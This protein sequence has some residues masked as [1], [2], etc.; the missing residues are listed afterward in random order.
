MSVA[1]FIGCGHLLRLSVAR[2][3]A[4]YTES[5]GAYGGDE[6]DF[7]LRA[8]D[9]GYEIIELAGVHVWHDKTPLARDL[10][11]QHRSGVC[12]DLTLVLRR[13]P[14]VLVVPTVVVKFAKHLLFSIKHGLFRAGLLGMRDFLS[15]APEIWRARLPVRAASLAQFYSLSRAPRK[16]AG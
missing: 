15:A 10:P 16:A 3:L 1:Q 7:C 13:V 6:K 5:P 9:A 12:N 14:A 8:I 4:G 11:E 2:E